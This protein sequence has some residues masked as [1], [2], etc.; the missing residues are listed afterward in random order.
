MHVATS[1]INKLIDYCMN[2]P[3]DGLY[4]AASVEAIKKLIRKNEK[5]RK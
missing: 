4:T 1:T 5:L 3:E 2:T